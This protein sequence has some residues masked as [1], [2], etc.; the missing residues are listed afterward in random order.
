MARGDAGGLS[1]LDGGPPRDGEHESY[2]DRASPRSRALPGRA[3][4][5]SRPAVRAAPYRAHPLHWLIFALLYASL[6]FAAYKGFWLW[7]ATLERVIGIVFWRHDWYE[8]IYLSANVLIA[9]TL[10]C[11]VVGAE[12]HLRTP[13]ASSYYP[14]GSF[15]LRLLW[16]Y[17]HLCVITG[18]VIGGAVL[19]QEWAFRALV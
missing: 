7:R 12:S 18:V 14:P 3:S 11:I 17:A 5:V 19:L 10:F 6:L 2:S 16:R 15:L 9:I 13:L 8:T 1:G 4:T